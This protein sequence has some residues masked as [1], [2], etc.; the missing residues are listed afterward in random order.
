MIPARCPVL[1]VPLTG[2]KGRPHHAS[3]SIDQIIPAKGYTKDNTVVV[4][5]R[6]NYLKR[7]ATIEELQQIARFY[8][9]LKKRRKLAKNPT[10]GR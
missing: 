4:S 10:T 9:R 2:G 7:D 6:V 8:T 5:W 3:P 1:G